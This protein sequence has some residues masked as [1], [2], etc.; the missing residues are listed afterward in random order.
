MGC[1]S[2]LTIPMEKSKETVSVITEPVSA[3]ETPSLAASLA[4]LAVD[5]S[6]ETAEHGANEEQL[7]A[8][9]LIT[10]H[11]RVYELGAEA[12][13]V[14]RSLKGQQIAVVS[15]AGD[16]RQGK[17]YILNRLAQAV[18]GFKTAYTS[19]PCTHGIWM[20]PKPVMLEGREHQMASCGPC[21]R[22]C[23]PSNP[24]CCQHSLCSRL[25]LN[26]MPTEHF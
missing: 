15:I 16:L 14:L 11:D 6:S 20:W 5:S 4:T 17:S 1:V 18:G 9:P 10:L 3:A 2:S 13:A 25:V 19:D 21:V 12:A 8:L 22:K 7:R 24:C 23:Q 26:Q